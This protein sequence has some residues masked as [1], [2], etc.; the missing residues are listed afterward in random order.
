MLAM[1]SLFWGDS[2]VDDFLKEYG[3][4]AA[5]RKIII[6]DEK[7]LSGRPHVGSLRSYVMHAILSDVLTSRDVENI[8]LY[9]INDTDAFDSVPSY[10]PS[11]W[12]EHLGKRLKD[13]P[14]PDGKAENYAMYFAKEYTDALV[15][16]MYNSEFYVSSHKYEAGEYDKY[17]KLALDNKDKIREI[18][19]EVSGSVKDENWY[20]CQVVCDKCGKIATTV[21]TGWNGKEVDYECSGDVGY[22]RG[23][24]HKGTK[25]PFGGHATM[26]WKVEWAAKFCVMKVDLEGAGKDHYA[27]GGSRHVSNRICKEVFDH[28]HPFDVRHE[29]ILMGGAKMSS[30][31]GVGATAVE[32]EELLP[33]YIFRFMM[34]Q[35]DVMKTISFD[36]AG[37]TIPVLFDQYD[38][39]C[40]DYFGGGEE[41][42]EHK[43]R[44]FEFTHFYEKDLKKFDRFLP[45]FSHI[46]FYVQ[47]PH[48]DIKAKVEEM[49]GDKLTEADIEEM[50][51]RIEYAKKWL[52]TCSPE[53]Y[54]FKV[55]EEVPEMA[56]EL[57]KEQKN[58]L[59]LLAEFLDGNVNAKGEDIQGFIHEQKAELEMQPMDIFRS[60]YVSILGKESGPQAGWLIEALEK[61]FLIDRF[62]KVSKL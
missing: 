39:V 13:V 50:N 58:F 60:I 31:S 36:P 19:R 10:V 1:K 56:G 4:E 33:L 8:F 29:F 20:P 54:I 43:N 47:M 48:V 41:V 22:A 12:K 28:K 35:K 61:V 49:K 42:K 15:Q 52:E 55:Q 27:A 62:Q 38:G 2:I 32:L 5:K 44:I 46:A 16:S 53:K 17:I 6:R 34:I 9:E 3:D 30:S 26:P 25:S 24:S 21:V 37:D 23:C 14:S 11:E 59:G 57:S 18:Y 7:T 45:R 40:K 51:F